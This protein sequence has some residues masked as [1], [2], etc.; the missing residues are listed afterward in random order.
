MMGFFSN[1]KVWFAVG[2]IAVALLGGMYVRLQAATISSL[3][4]QNTTLKGQLSTA[5]QTIKE[6]AK[7]RKEDQERIDTLSDQFEQAEEQKHE[8]LNQLAQSREAQR[9]AALADP[10][11]V[12]DQLTDNVAGMFEDYYRATAAGDP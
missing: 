5:N 3:E 2:G 10:V 12:S 9:Q 1:L 11:G 4:Q 7:A 8:A 6:Q